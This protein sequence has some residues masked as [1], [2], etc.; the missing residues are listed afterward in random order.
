MSFNFMF[1]TLKLMFNSDKTS[2][3]LERNRE[4]I[5]RL[6]FI[7]TFQPG[8]KINTNQL[9]VESNSLFT[10]LKRKLN[11]E[12]RQSTLKFITETIERSFE[13]IQSMLL[14]EQISEKMICTNILKDMIQAINGLNNIQKTYKE[15]KI[16]C[17]TI[18]TLIDNIKAKCTEIKIKKPE[19]FCSNEFNNNNNILEDNTISLTSTTVLEQPSI[20]Q[21]TKID[22]NEV[23]TNT[24]GDNIK[25]DNIKGDKK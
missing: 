25:S 1:S 14:S 12:S 16:F 3:N 6:K 7:A 20:K 8:E 19:L 18:D 4:I 13:I 9:L 10:P 17:C 5:T 11:G 23:K 24:K 2:A 15:D 21:T 22:N